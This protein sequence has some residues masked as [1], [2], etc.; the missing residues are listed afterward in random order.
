MFIAELI[1]RETLFLPRALAKIDTQELIP[2]KYWFGVT[3][4]LLSGIGL[5][6]IH[7]NKKTRPWPKRAP[8]QPLG[9]IFMKVPFHF[10]T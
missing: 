3:V 2:F 6:E 9:Q 1:T 8:L 10:F 5:T 4:S 7:A